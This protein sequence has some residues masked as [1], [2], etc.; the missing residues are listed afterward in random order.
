MLDWVKW[1]ILGALV[2]GL[3]A[4]HLNLVHKAVEANNNEWNVKL[5]TT[6]RKN[7]EIEK[8]I[9][10]G[11]LKLEESKN[12]EINKLNDSVV[13]LNSRLSKRPSRTY[14]YRDAPGTEKACT[15]AELYREDGQFLTGEA[16]RAERIRVERDY[17]YEQY[18]Q[19]RKKL[20]ERNQFK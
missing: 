9:M 14:V 8:N 5:I 1:A 15:G 16:G 20:D 17:Y 11:V 6:E 3:G 7:K 2:V 19:A 12:A 18:E 10:I 13:S 4:I